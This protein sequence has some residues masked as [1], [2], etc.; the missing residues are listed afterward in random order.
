M[1]QVIL[2]K[3]L[4][5]SVSLIINIIESENLTIYSEDFCMML[6]GYQLILRQDCY[7]SKQSQHVYE[8]AK[9]LPRLED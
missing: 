4:V 8:K 2:G 6:L 3:P 1:D 7:Y 9:L 5:I